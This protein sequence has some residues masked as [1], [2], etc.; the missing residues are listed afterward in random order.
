MTQYEAHDASIEKPNAFVEDDEMS[1]D[2][3]LPVVFT[4]TYDEILQGYLEKVSKPSTVVK[5]C[6][7]RML[8]RSNICSPTTEESVERNVVLTSTYEDVM[9]Q[10]DNVRSSQDN[11]AYPKILKVKMLKDLQ[12]YLRR[13]DVPLIV[14]Y[15]HQLHCYKNDMHQGHLITLQQASRSLGMADLELDASKVF[16]IVHLRFLKTKETVTLK[17]PRLPDFK[18]AYKSLLQLPCFRGIA[19]LRRLHAV[20]NWLDVLLEIEP[21][22]A[23][24]QNLACDVLF[25]ALYGVANSISRSGFEV[26]FSQEAQ[27]DACS[28][29]GSQV[30]SEQVNTSHLSAPLQF[31]HED[32]HV[33]D[34][35]AAER[36]LHIESTDV[37][38]NRTSIAKLDDSNAEFMTCDENFELVA[39]TRAIDR[40]AGNHVAD[41]LA[42]PRTSPTMILDRSN[43]ST[44]T[45][46]KSD[47]S[48]NLDRAPISS[49]IGNNSTTP[50]AEERSA[51]LL[52]S[53]DASQQAANPALCTKEV[54]FSQNEEFNSIRYLT[55]LEDFSLSQQSVEAAATRLAN[56]RKKTPTKSRSIKT[57]RKQPDRSR[58]EDLKQLLNRIPNDVSVFSLM[59][60]Y[61][62]QEM[63]RMCEAAN[64]KLDSSATIAT[65]AQKLCEIVK[66]HVSS[67]CIN[68]PLNLYRFLKA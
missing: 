16:L 19:N 13:E 5:E 14:N 28:T 36:A 8:N 45:L 43:H 29:N 21:K 59:Q 57:D 65:V 25:T 18:G 46:I 26:I 56:P 50:L 58:P 41:A 27:G 32:N 52:H 51:R 37:A 42:S 49:L 22:T 48:V 62:I 39:S 30:D 9:K 38:I 44:V 2:E 67:S 17:Y 53:P 24:N 1:T 11:T 47:A 3:E 12:I 60:T 61:N 68:D 34:N 20:A 33:L 54:Q 10:M 35:H 64:V 15:Y 7:L 66:D 55:N 40:E 23:D 63:C 4:Q 31:A 6:G